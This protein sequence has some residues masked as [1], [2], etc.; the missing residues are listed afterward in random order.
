MSTDP[1]DYNVAP[2][3]GYEA[4]PEVRTP[5]HN[6]EA[7]RAMLGAVFIGRPRAAAAPINAVLT[8]VRAMLNAA[9][10]YREPHRH[11]YRAMCEVADDGL[12]I[13]VVTVA[14]KL[15]AQGLLEAVGGANV[16]ARLSHENPSSSNV[17]Y[18]AK[19]ILRTKALRDLA[20][21]AAVIQD[22]AYGNPSD[23]NGFICRSE[24]ALL[25]ITRASEQ[26][27]FRH[28]REAGKD[29]VIK[30]E[31]KQQGTQSGIPI[32]WPDMEEQ[33]GAIEP[34]DLTVLAARPGMGKS[35]MAFQWA[36]V[37]AIEHLVPVGILSLEMRDDQ[38]FMRMATQSA[39]IDNSLLTGAKARLSEAQWA[40]FL[41]GM[42]RVVDAPVWVG[43]ERFTLREATAVMRRMHRRHDVRVFFID[44]LQIVS[45]S[46]DRAK[47]AEHVKRVVSE[48]KKLAK[49]LRVNIIALAQL[50]RE[51]ERRADKRPMPSD[52]GESGQIEREADQ[53]IFLYR[54]DYYEAESEDRGVAEAIVSKNR[55]GSTGTVRLRWTGSS[56]VFD[57]L[58]GYH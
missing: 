7:E 17:E 22:E 32:P 24:E 46:D 52:L 31:A 23:F 58:E 50:N 34:G 21:L 1:T 4:P 42:K 44:Y 14:D 11:I 18:Y 56:M 19:I 55:N 49:E 33:L 6:D 27:S 9:D 28:I 47:D 45:K 35:A 20:A 2:P 41:G 30:L 38:V 57:T 43:E 10:L 3:I 40:I 29:A 15:M 53:I 16:L 51:C 13:D 8:D 26:V 54:D 36:G 37:L 48:L 25:A 12:E 39:R 5:P